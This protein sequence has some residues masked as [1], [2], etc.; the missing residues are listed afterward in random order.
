[1]NDSQNIRQKT[2][3][4]FETL[5][6]IYPNVDHQTLIRASEFLSLGLS[7]NETLQRLGKPTLDELDLTPDD[8]DEDF[9]RDLIIS[10]FTK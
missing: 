4:Q 1:M 7:A 2:L 3:N 8:L 5:K 10:H 9:F 6:S